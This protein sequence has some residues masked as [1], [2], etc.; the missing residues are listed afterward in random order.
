MVPN[1]KIGYV[2]VRLKKSGLYK[3]YLKILKR[4]F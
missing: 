4:D 2:N 3:K 1:I